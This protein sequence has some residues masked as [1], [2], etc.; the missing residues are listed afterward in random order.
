MALGNSTTGYGCVSRA[1]HWIGFF[2]VAAAFGLAW[3]MTEMASGP[4][5][6]RLYGIHKSIGALVLGLG[7]LRIVWTVAQPAPKPLGALVPW[8]RILAKAVHGLL[9][10]WMVAMPLSGWLMSAAAGRPVSVFG[11]FVLPNP[12]APDKAMAHTFKEMHEVL[13]ALGLLL[14]GLH[15]AAALWHHFVLKDGTLRRMLPC[16]LGGCGCE[17]G[18]CAGRDKTKPDDDDKP[19]VVRGCC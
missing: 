7:L 1:I 8:Q 2:L 6:F 17:G 5:K 3:T 16:R 9:L 4:D 14:I 11:W 13:A 10:L 18:A 19:P 15:V 12:V